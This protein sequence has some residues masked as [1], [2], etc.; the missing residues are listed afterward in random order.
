MVRLLSIRKKIPQTTHRVGLA[1]EPTGPVLCALDADGHLRHRHLF[2]ATA[3]VDAAVAEY[4]R[5][6]GLK[7]APCNLVLGA[8]D[9]AILPAEAPEVAEAE[10]DQALLW[11]LRDRLDTPPDETVLSSFPFASGLEKP[12]KRMRHAVVARKA[13]IR[14]LVERVRAMGLALQAIDIPELVWRNLAERLPQN[15]A[16]VG[17]MVQGS[18]GLSIALFRAGELYVSRQLAGIASLEEPGIADALSLQIL[19]TLDYYDSEL[20]Q[21][22]LAQIYLQPIGGADAVLARE[23]AANLPVPVS[24]LRLSELVTTAL[25]EDPAL[26]GLVLNAL[27]AALRRK[28]G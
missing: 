2:R 13:R 16:G 11:N 20:G 23:L 14:A 12:G 9:Y 5:A 22:P 25:P 27:G 21:R 15:E 18:R 7:G 19:R 6:H 10:I 3:D 17:L 1:L 26:D 8:E 4:V 28:E 24:L